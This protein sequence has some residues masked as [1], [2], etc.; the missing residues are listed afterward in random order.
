M[1]LRPRCGDD[2]G[3]GCF[4]VSLSWSGSESE[5]CCLFCSHCCELGGGIY[6]ERND[7]ISK[8]VEE[9]GFLSPSL[10]SK[11]KLRPR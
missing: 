2:V 5:C 10:G 6:Q 3:G 1:G 11:T 8:L 4:G 9:R 7:R